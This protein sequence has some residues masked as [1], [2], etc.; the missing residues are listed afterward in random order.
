MKVLAAIVIPPHLRSSG[1]VNAGTALS[2]ALAHYCT[3][4]VALMSTEERCEPLG[5]ARLLQ[6]RSRNILA[7]TQGFLPNKFRS[8]LYRSDIPNL[9]RRGSYDLVHIHNVIPTLEMKRIAHACVE[10]GIPYVVATHGF[11]EATS[12]GAAYGLGW[13]ERIAW[14]LLIERPLSYVVGH[15]SNLFIGAPTELPLLAQLGVTADR[16]VLVTNGVDPLYLE[17]APAADIAAVCAKFD[18]PRAKD[19]CTP[20]GFFLANH[21]ENKGLWVL[22]DAFSTT[23]RPYLLI[24]GGKQRD[25]NYQRYMARC[26]P[27]QHIVFTDYLTETEVRALFQY[28]DLFIFPTLADTLPLVILEAMASGLPILSTTVGGIP[29]QVDESYGCLVPPGDV[30]ALQQAFEKLTSN[31]KRLPIMG[32]QAKAVVKHRFNWDE[33]AQRAYAA[34]QAI[35]DPDTSRE[36]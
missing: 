24:V 34:Y 3:I 6:R 33:S 16:T 5:A 20:V 21:T 12:K 18:L 8:L 10:R 23:K 17:P 19:E 30:V 11:V 28:A 32:Q 1:A 2:K 22:L 35:L 29:Y 7:W 36:R 13:P 31:M 25:Y 4:D 9:I 14:K 27:N 15:A 26:A